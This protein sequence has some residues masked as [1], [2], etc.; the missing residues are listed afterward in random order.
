MFMFRFHDLCSFEEPRGTMERDGKG[1]NLLPAGFQLLYAIPLLTSCSF[2]NTKRR[3]SHCF[4]IRQ[5]LSH[6]PVFRLFV[7]AVKP[8][9]V[10]SVLVFSSFRKSCSVIAVNGQ[11]LILKGDAI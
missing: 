8:W 7:V 10:T 9:K 4:L 6:F 1:H 3:T 11:L 2:L 5:Y